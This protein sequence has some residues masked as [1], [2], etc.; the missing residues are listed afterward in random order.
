[1]PHARKEVKI[2]NSLGLHARPATKFVQLASKFRCKVSVRKDG[3]TVN[4]KSVM[5]MMMLAAAKGTNITIE[6]NGQ[7]AVEAVEALEGLIKERFGEE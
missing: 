5:G 2:Q 4:G 3:Q 7:D 6:A 1:M